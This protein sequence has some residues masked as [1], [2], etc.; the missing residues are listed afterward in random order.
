M[1]RLLPIAFAAVTMAPVALA[2]LGS[3]GLGGVG[4][5]GLGGRFTIPRVEAHTV[6][7]PGVSRPMLMGGLGAVGG[8]LGGG[9]LGGGFGGAS[10]MGGGGGVGGGLQPNPNWVGAA[11]M[12][13]PQLLTGQ[14]GAN[15]GAAANN[16]AGGGGQAGRPF[17]A[18][19]NPA[20]TTV[21]QGQAHRPSGA[22]PV[23]TVA[24]ARVAPSTAPVDAAEA[25]ARLL[26]FQQRQARSGSPS[27]QYALARR[28]LKGDGVE[29]NR[30][31]ARVWLEAAAK[32]G[33]GEAKAE[34]AS[35]GP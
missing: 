16:P 18:I 28:Y 34:L 25:D 4:G 30:A 6:G 11:A 23:A 21:A 19:Q 1:N 10:G 35:M 8:A 17:G 2:Q 26:A 20:D 5:G 22:T 31:V 32:A 15:A 24:V 29:A 9:G 27:A 13:M 33:S 7:I 14:G 3:Q 12:F